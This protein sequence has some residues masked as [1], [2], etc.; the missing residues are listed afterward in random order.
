MA[1]SARLFIDFWNFSLNWRDRVPSNEHC[2]WRKLPAEI[3]AAS[4]QILNGAGLTEP[5]DLNE[6][7]VYASIDTPD[8]RLKGWLDTFLNRLPS[9]RVTVKER[10]LRPAKLHCRNCDQEIERCAQCGTAYVRS[11]ER[12]LIHKSSPIFCPLHGKERLIWRSC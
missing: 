2:D 11:A 6:T 1:Y 4:Q 9:F 3:V 5:V 8:T 12:A 10:S 7:L